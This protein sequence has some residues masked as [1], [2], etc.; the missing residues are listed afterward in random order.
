MFNPTYPGW[1]ATSDDVKDDGLIEVTFTLDK[2][3]GSIADISF[4][5]TGVSKIQAFAQVKG[6][7]TDFQI[8]EVIPLY[9]FST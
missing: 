1:S 8:Q 4:N 5:I 7:P 6:Q 2:N 3:A 9:C